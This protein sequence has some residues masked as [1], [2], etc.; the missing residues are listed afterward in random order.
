MEKYEELKTGAILLFKENKRV[1]WYGNFF[2]R[3]KNPYDGRILRLQYINMEIIKS[4]GNYNT[5][6]KSIQSWRPRI[7]WSGPETINIK[8]K[9]KVH[10]WPK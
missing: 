7:L 3:L 5:D 9:G 1:N 8:M 2:M 6:L 4:S 10:R